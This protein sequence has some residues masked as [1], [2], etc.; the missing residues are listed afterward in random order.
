MARP[1]IV[2]TGA[3]GFVGRHLLDG[4]KE[5]FSVHGIARRSQAQCGVP[6]HPNITWSQVDITE[7]EPVAAAF[8]WIRGRG[9][10]DAV[11]HLAAHYDF[12][13]RDSSDY[14]R[15]NVDG[16]RHVLEACR[17]FD[18][19]RF[20]FASSVA[21]CRFPPAG[22][23]VTEDTEPN[24]DHP[25]ARSKRAGEELVRAAAP[26]IPTCVVR[27]AAL[28]SDWCEY[29]PLF[30]FL[31]AW[32]S[33]DWNARVIGGRGSFA[34]PYLHIRC[35]VSLL[36]HL[37]YHLDR[38]NPG[39]TFIASPDGAVAIRDIFDAATL[40]HFGE[41]RRP[42]FV[43]RITASAWLHLQDAVG[44]VI[45]RRPFERPWMAR[46]LDR[47]LTVDAS[48]TRQ[49]LG[50]T[51][52]PR[53]NLIRRMPFLVDN[54]RTQPLRWSR[55]NHAAM[56]K[57]VAVEGLKIQWLL[58]QH[59]PEICRRHV[60]ALL[61]PANRSRF[62]LSG[63]VDR[64]RVADRA[65]RSISSLRC[66]L[67]T[68]EMEPVGSYCRDVAAGCF[69]DGLNVDQ[70]CAAFSNLGSISIE[71]LTAGRSQ[72]G[73]DRAIHERISMAIQ[74]GI[75]EVLDEFEVR[76]CEGCAP[77]PHVSGDRISP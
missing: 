39:E 24:A 59:Q 42:I 41:R 2:V 48:R 50:W 53:F 32:L 38:P 31:N 45:G 9:P 20:I 28:Y 51:S 60:D 76:S 15:T 3:S 40:A 66:T 8:E 12:T 1:R 65:R 33:N 19:E 49:R 16:L 5:C 18:L 30:N 63:K 77:C 57:E 43:P 36:S 25:Y 64:E 22:G 72:S 58:E 70:V 67:R 54:L 27:F 37:L 11:V 23:M 52:R 44:R 14:R 55:L 21:A 7:P 26:E 61:D 10:V 6:P 47:Q 62:G 68:R 29:P 13:G 75:D 4:I 34:I 35:A 17:R 69:E 56:R 73:L 74:Y 71:V 46:Y